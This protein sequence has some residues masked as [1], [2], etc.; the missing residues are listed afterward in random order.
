[1]KVRFIAG[2]VDPIDMTV[3]VFILIF[4]TRMNMKFKWPG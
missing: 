3:R 4:V 2:G 1:M